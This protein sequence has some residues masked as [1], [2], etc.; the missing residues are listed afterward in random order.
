MREYL[1]ITSRDRV[2]GSAYSYTV[3]L[4]K[5]YEDVKSI[6]VRQIE[7]NNTIPAVPKPESYIEIDDNGTVDA[8]TVYISVAFPYASGQTTTN[9]LNYLAVDANRAGNYYPPDYSASIRNFTR[10]KDI[11]IQIPPGVY[12]T[13]TD[14]A[15]AIDNILTKSGTGNYIQDRILAA[16]NTTYSSAGGTTYPVVRC[17]YESTL[18]ALCFYSSQFVYISFTRCTASTYYSDVA[19]ERKALAYRTMT[20]LGF[21]A[22]RDVVVIDQYNGS[23]YTAYAGSG[24]VY[25]AGDSFRN[26]SGYPLT[27]GL[28]AGTTPDYTPDDALILKITEPD[29]S[30]FTTCTDATNGFLTKIPISKGTG[31]GDAELVNYGNEAYTKYFTSRMAFDSFTIQ[32]MTESGYRYF[33]GECEHTFILEITM[34]ADEPDDDLARIVNKGF[35][36]M[37][38]DDY[39]RCANLST[40]PSGMVSRHIERFF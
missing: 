9:Y 17:R 11:A 26:Y 15:T 4:P 12:S 8:N 6:A 33:L 14:L 34:G 10:Y 29:C 36:K 30:L 38:Y 13:G 2:S 24:V 31:Y 22:V 39:P 20:L 37:L 7:F 28:A 23:G 16:I 35:A 1:S 21:T 25:S 40:A 3:K 32:V 18:N 27:F 5:R 19:N